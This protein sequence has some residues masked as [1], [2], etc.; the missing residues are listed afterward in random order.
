M[1]RQVFT[2]MRYNVRLQCRMGCAQVERQRA[3][4]ARSG[5]FDVDTNEALSTKTF[6]SAGFGNFS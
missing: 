1:A 5:K 3:I 2:G 6:I 4:A